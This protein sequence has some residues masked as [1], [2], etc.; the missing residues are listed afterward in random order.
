MLNFKEKPA[1][2]LGEIFPLPVRGERSSQMNEQRA[3]K[4]K[5]SLF[6]AGWQSTLTSF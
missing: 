2:G 5:S 4:A 3:L 6:S 1:L